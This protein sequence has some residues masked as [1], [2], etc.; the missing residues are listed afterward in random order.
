MDAKAR[1]NKDKEMVTA[2]ID[3]L[4]ERGELERT[5]QPFAAQIGEAFAD[6]RYTVEEVLAQGDLVIARIAISGT[7]AGTFAGQPATGRAVRL[8]QFR[9]FRM[10]GGEVAE[11]WGWFDTGTLLPQIQS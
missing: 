7:H 5:D 9:E 1:N 3:G 11:H 2:F 10:D 4:W 6:R 8:T